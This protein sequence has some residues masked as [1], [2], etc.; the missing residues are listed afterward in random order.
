M[1]LVC[2]LSSS[3]IT[4][5]EKTTNLEELVWRHIWANLNLIFFPREL[6]LERWEIRPLDLPLDFPNSPV[7]G[8]RQS[9]W[10]RLT[11]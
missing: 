7:F 11:N 3:H 6:D 10:G 1:F 9:C 8:A 5:D 4:D 2:N